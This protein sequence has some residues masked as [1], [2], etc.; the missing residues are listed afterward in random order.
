MKAQVAIDAGEVNFSGGHVLFVEGGADSLDVSVLSSVL[1]ITVKPLGPSAYVR[2]VAQAMHPAFP[3]YYFLVDRDRLDDDEVETLWQ[4]FPMTDTPNLLAWRKKEVE[5]YFL[6]P[7]YVM[8]SKYFAKGKSE[9][10]VQRFLVRYSRPYVFMEAANRVIVSIREQLKKKWIEKFSDK[11]EFPDAKSALEKLLSVPEFAFQLN[12]VKALVDVEN[13]TLKF[14]AELRRLLGEGDA[15]TW[16]QGRWLDLMPAK[17]M[18]RSLLASPL[19]KVVGRD[20]KPLSGMDKID[21]IV[22]E[23]LTPDKKL[24]PDFQELERLMKMQLQGTV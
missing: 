23:L 3:N 20:K 17:A 1:N 6:D 8:Q 10:D 24:P 9:T 11:T 4:K 7:E 13:L 19:F 16:G 21:V 12:K 5:S 2:S 15:L 22:K 14:Q 18:M